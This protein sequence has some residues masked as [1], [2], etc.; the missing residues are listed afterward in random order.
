MGASVKRL[1][2]SGRFTLERIV[3]ISHLIGFTL[4]ELAHEAAVSET[5]LHTLSEAQEKEPCF[6]PE[7]LLLVAVC[8]LNQWRIEDITKIYRSASPS[9]SN[10]WPSSTACA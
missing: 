7:K 4:A 3:E 5:R 8:V 10:A 9:A 1:F 6:R 2:A